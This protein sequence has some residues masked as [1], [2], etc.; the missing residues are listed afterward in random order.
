MTAPDP[1]RRWAW[2]HAWPAA[3]AALV[4]VAAGCASK[5]TSPALSPSRTYRMGFSAIPPRPDFPTQLAMLNLMVSHS[6]AA[7]MLSEVPWDSLLAGTRPDSIVLRNQ[8]GLADWYRG[9]GLR[10]VVSLDPTNGLDRSA[11][12]APLVA[13]GR[14][15]TEPAIQLLY[16]RY[17]V[18]L[19]TLVHPDDFSVASET[20]LVRAIAPAPL[21]AALVAN[22][23][24]AATAI[25][26]ADANVKVF[27]TVQ[28]EVA[29]GR[30][31]PPGAYVGIGQDLADFPFAQALGLSSY[32]YL[33]GF[34]DPADLPDDYFARIVHDAGK[35]ALMIEGG[36]TSADVGAQA[37]TPDEQ[38]RYIAREAALLDAAQSVV[39]WFQITFSDLDLAYF[40]VGVAPF[41]YLG[42]VDKNLSAKPALTA[43]DQ[44]F[45]KPLR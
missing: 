2:R 25:H 40:P 33:A 4:V 18:A 29:W 24:A 21:Y 43:W 12:A 28:V 16:R 45:A 15:L 31:A 22:A 30:L 14:S 41:A 38:K 23:A 37:S 27:T 13:A 20:N 1:C 9:H 17:A 34:A 42:M 39:A 10:I 8:V 26:A 5:V 11:D 35:P 6:D 44:V 32:P 19:D 7:L 36:W 3:V